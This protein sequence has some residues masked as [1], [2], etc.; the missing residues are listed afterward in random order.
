MDRRGFI[1][2]LKHLMWL[3]KVISI[4]WAE[5][6][7]V[8]EWEAVLMLSRC[9][10]HIQYGSGW[11]SVTLAAFL[12]WLMSLFL[13]LPYLPLFFS[14]EWSHLLLC[15]P[16]VPLVL[17]KGKMS[18]YFSFSLSPFVCFSLPPLCLSSQFHPFQKIILYQIFMCIIT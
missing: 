7:I 14:T 11:V 2:L 6:W 4:V 8:R 5:R 16:F 13:F 12:F 3:A 9:F 1:Y 17:F 15:G 18:E 10:T